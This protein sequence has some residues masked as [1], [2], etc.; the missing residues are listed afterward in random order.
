MF[1]WTHASTVMAV[2]LLGKAFI[3]AAD[4]MPPPPPACSYWLRWGYDFI[5][6]AASNSLRVGLKWPEEPGAGKN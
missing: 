1:P 4:S 2:A 5:Q 6:R 3:M